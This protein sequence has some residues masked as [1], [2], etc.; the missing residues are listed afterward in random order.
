MENVA[1]FLQKCKWTLKF[2][3]Y[4]EIKNKEQIVALILILLR[5][6]FKFLM[7]NLISVTN[8]ANYLV[9]YQM[10]LQKLQEV[11]NWPSF[12]LNKKIVVNFAYF[13]LIAKIENSWQHWA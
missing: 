5:T 1:L 4:R 9:K 6:N 3:F 13:N 2:A 7:P 10:M 12:Q 11:K 8:F